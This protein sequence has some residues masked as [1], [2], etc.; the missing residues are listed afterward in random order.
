M[1]LLAKGGIGRESDMEEC[2]GS[3]GR[4]GWT[5]KE[6]LNASRL[7]CISKADFCSFTNVLFHNNKDHNV[8]LSLAGIVAMLH[9]T[10]LT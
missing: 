7:R 5:G 3:L 10:H 1:L 4:E 2:W 9:L 6:I 8:I